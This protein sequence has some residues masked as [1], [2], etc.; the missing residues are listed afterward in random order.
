MET[1]GEPAP[2]IEVVVPAVTAEE[3]AREVIDSTA[4]HLERGEDRAAVMESL[5]LLDSV[6]TIFSGLALPHGQVN[7]PARD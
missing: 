3:R 6:T 2:L 7:G 5:W 4:E 1:L